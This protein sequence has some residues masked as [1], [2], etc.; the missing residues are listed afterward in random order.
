MTG[1]LASITHG[2]EFLVC[3]KPS[4]EMSRLACEAGENEEEVGGPENGHFPPIIS[5]PTPYPFRP[6]LLAT[7]RRNVVNYNIDKKIQ[8][9]ID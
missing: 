6:V 9:F 1:S 8:V 2:A 3:S 7:L 4:I 5:L